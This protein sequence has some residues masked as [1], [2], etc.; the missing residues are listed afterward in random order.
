MKFFSLL[1]I[2]LFVLL[3]TAF[4]Q[5]VPHFYPKPLPVGL[6]NTPRMSE[7]DMEAYLQNLQ[8]KQPAEYQRLMLLDARLRAF[9]KTATT[10][11]LFWAYN[12]KED[13][14]YQV[15][16]TLR[17]QG[18][19]TQIW[20]EDSSWTNSYVTQAEVDSIYLALEVKSY[21]G[22]I[23][24]NTGIIEIDTLLFG[25]PPNRDGDGITDF[26]ILDIKDDYNPDEP[27]S[28]FVAGYFF[29]ND[30]QNTANSNRMDLLYLDSR[31]GI[32]SDGKRSVR[33][34]L[35]TTA[36]EFQHLIHYNYDRDEETWVNE[37]LSELSSTYCGF[38]L[39][40]PYLYLQDPN[41][42]LILWSDDVR[43]YARVGLWTLY[44]A[45][46]FGNVFIKSY[47][48]SP[49]NG[50]VGFNSTLQDLGFMGT[51]FD[52][53]YSDWIIANYLND[54]Q[55]DP[56]YGY[57]N[58]AAAGIRAG[59]QRTI[60]Q[61]PENVTGTIRQYGAEYFRFK[62]GDTLRIDFEGVPPQVAVV[63]RNV[64]VT[65]LF[66]PT[67]NRLEIPGFNPSDEFVAILGN[68]AP[69][70]QY[71]FSGWA[72]LSVQYAEI[73]YG[74]GQV[75]FAINF[76]GMA[77]NKFTVPESGFSLAS[78]K[79]YNTSQ[80]MPIVA[81]VFDATGGGLPGN[82][83]AQPL[84]TTLYLERSWIEIPL[85]PAP[86][87][88][89]AGKLLF[90]AIE[91]SSDKYSLGYDDNTAGIGKSFLNLSG[92]WRP[93][94][95]FTVGGGTQ[96]TGNWM[97]TAVF[98]GKLYP[99][100]EPPPPP[101]AEDKP[102]T[103]LAYPNPSFGSL[104][105]KTGVMDAGN[106]R[107]ELYSML[108]QRVAVLEQGVPVAGTYILDWDLNRMN[109]AAGIYFC[110]GVFYNGSDGKTYRSEAQKIIYLK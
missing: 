63:H 7:M 3:L 32:F 90:V 23:N 16:A 27:N 8:E 44:V 91:V 67:G 52:D 73:G 77:A 102:I 36:H 59:L 69:D 42:N 76:Q 38:G 54:P 18:I 110:R 105:F 103:L 2:H 6:C 4:S 72:P 28:S 85:S 47:T 97:I 100:G 22:S 48:Q 106:I 87:P 45:E 79:V 86:G 78:F 43:D 31:P 82:E 1:L 37:G 20:V 96:L 109:L 74:D 19:L 5:D 29:P 34:V 14:F 15:S 84:N 64:A 70:R 39:D 104:T 93:L 30:Q 101:V 71:A 53:V 10:T 61:Y 55:F 66:S 26:L 24:P 50:I 33:R 62:G 11:K 75:D 56:R 98:E 51:S 95:D 46:Q 40:F 58:E 80:N 92:Q 12:I 21:A 41:R 17:K 9:N 83:I 13:K 107:I 99:S 25:V 57:Q 89:S 88:F 68:L 35:S 94:S 81:H 108:G 65:E 49:L 60:V